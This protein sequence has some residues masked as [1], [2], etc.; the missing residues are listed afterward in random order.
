MPKSGGIAWPS[1]AVNGLL[2]LLFLDLSFYENIDPQGL[3]NPA[4]VSKIW[5]KH[6][7]EGNVDSKKSNSGS[8]KVSQT[9][10][11]EVENTQ[12]AQKKK[13]IQLKRLDSLLMMSLI[14]NDLNQAFTKL[15]RDW[16]KNSARLEQ[17]NGLVQKSKLLVPNKSHKDLS[18]MV[19]GA[20]SEQEIF[21]KKERCILLQDG[22]RT[23]TL[24]ITSDQQYPDLYAIEFVWVR[25]KSEFQKIKFKIKIKKREDL[26]IVTTEMWEQLPQEFIVNFLASCFTEVSSNTQNDYHFG[27]SPLV[28]V[29]LQ[30]QSNLIN[31][32]IINNLGD[33]EQLKL[34]FSVDAQK[35]AFEL[36]KL[37]YRVLNQENYFLF[38]EKIKQ[39]EYSLQIFV[40]E[41]I[42]QGQFIEIQIKLNSLQQSIIVLDQLQII[43]I[44]Y[45]EKMLQY[46]IDP[47]QIQQIKSRYA[48]QIYDLKDNHLNYLKIYKLKTRIQQNILNNSFQKSFRMLRQSCRDGNI[49]ND[50]CV[51]RQ[52][53]YYDERLQKCK[54]CDVKNCQLCQSED[55]CSECK[56]G[57]YPQQ[58]RF[59][60][61]KCS[62][63]KTNNCVSCPNNECNQC[64]SPYALNNQRDC[65][66]C[67]LNQGNF[68]D[69][70]Q[71]CKQCKN[72]QQCQ[73][74]A[75]NQCIQNTCNK[76]RQFIPQSQNPQIGTCISCNTQNGYFVSKNAQCLKCHNSCKTCDGPNANN[77]LTCQDGQV[78]LEQNNQC[79]VCE[80]NKGF[81]IDQKSGKCNVCDQNCKTCQNSSN[82][83]TSCQINM[84]LDNKQCVNC[85][86]QDGLF[87]DQ[88]GKCVKCD[89]ACQTCTKQ[90]ASHN[91]ECQCQQG[92]I[93]YPGDS[94]NK[95]SL[96]LQP[97]KLEKIE[98]SNPFLNQGDK[99]YSYTLNNI[100]TLH[101]N[102]A[103]RKDE[104]Q[105]FSILINPSS[106]VKDKDYFII[107]QEFKDNLI[108]VEI[109]VYQHRR[110]DEIKYTL[111]GSDNT[112]K[113]QN[114]LFTSK[115]YNKDQ[116][117]Q[118]DSAVKATQG[119]SE[120]LTPS[121]GSMKVLLDN[122][123]KF[124]ILCFLSNF[125]QVLAPIT[126]FKDSLP[127]QVY[128]GGQLGASFIFSELKAVDDINFSE[129]ITNSNNSA[130]QTNSRQLILNY[131]NS[132]SSQQQNYYLNQKQNQ[133]I[134]QQNKMRKLQQ[135]EHFNETNQKLFQNY[136]KQNQSEKQLG[137]VQ[138]KDKNRDDR[139]GNHTKPSPPKN[140]TTAQSKEINPIPDETQQS[141]I[142]QTLSGYGLQPYLY[143][144]F[145]FA[146][147]IIVISS[148]SILLCLIARVTL[149]G[150]QYTLQIVDKSVN[151]VC[152]FSQGSITSGLF[153]IY[154]SLQ[155]AQGRGLAV[156]QLLVNVMFVLEMFYLL[157]VRDIEYIQN[158]I[159]N[160]FDGINSKLKGAK[161]YIFISFLKKYIIIILFLLLSSYPVTCSF[162]VSAIFF[163]QI[164][165]LVK[166]R[167]FNLRIINYLKILQEFLIS[168]FFALLGT[169][170]IKYRE[171]LKQDVVS[172]QELLQTKQFSFCLIIFIFMCLSISL[173]IF[174][175]RL[176]VTFGQ[177]YMKIYNYLK[178]RKKRD[179]IKS[180]EELISISLNS[181]PLTSLNISKNKLHIHAH[182]SKSKYLK[183]VKHSL[184]KSAS[185]NLTQNL[186][187]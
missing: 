154:Y 41:I 42:I 149:S 180:S 13:L 33:V 184:K 120:L 179:I 57:Y 87:I 68:I 75:D 84:G 46:T 128:I 156:F 28:E 96:C 129:N 183:T 52:G 47:S 167:F 152:S 59:N 3:V 5:N 163:L 153:S 43:K 53:Y 77:C 11:M 146:H 72:C 110:I 73:G 48:Q 143:S 4:N 51:C 155:F 111:N 125:V 80:V 170:I 117:E 101:L 39:N 83:C 12:I 109:E 132:T 124:Q 174:L 134:S 90:G 10:K 36:D 123:K 92:Y 142:I 160:F 177:L 54:E 130:N 99:K 162:I 17:L 165:Y 66:Q 138:N 107:A 121:E 114:V 166:Y 137:N 61:N 22:A 122:L 147:L 102:R 140:N 35:I 127:P 37:Y 45:R 133:E 34:F 60:Q 105:D 173:L 8:I 55:L 19:W 65:I 82:F 100:I 171:M 88:N 67:N 63:C 32:S 151:F 104:R 31:I 169:C 56:P 62:R 103:P 98:I 116:L 2:K 95:E 15:R 161:S 78:I 106:L 175:I 141:S 150:K 93:Y 157:K 69:S 24:K 18:V 29:Y 91:K 172:N 44:Q 182:S 178:N 119:L 81:F 85:L 186:E 1:S 16:K 97:L 86:Q 70:N 89:S 79:G 14:L 126:L 71:I 21:D 7:E 131:S 9:Q 25:I 164:I 144:N 139:R 185:P 74:E 158:N 49:Q 30:Q 135:I 112:I 113:L 20:I 38:L 159:P 136:E 64:Q 187:D 145:I 27:F 40:N 6:L 115:D 26:I 50:E 168:T 181:L 94:E 148:I 76:G 23:Q 118:S 58:K 176:V 108:I